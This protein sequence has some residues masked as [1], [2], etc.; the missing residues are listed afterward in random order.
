MFLGQS[1]RLPS[2]LYII[3]WRC[4]LWYCD[5]YLGRTG[6]AWMSGDGCT[7][8]S[9]C[10]TDPGCRRAQLH[11]TEWTFSLC[12]LYLYTLTIK[13]KRSM[14]LYWRTPTMAQIN[15]HRMFLW[16][17][18]PYSISDHWRSSFCLHLFLWG[19]SRWSQ[20]SS[21]RNTSCCYSSEPLHLN[22][23]TVTSLWWRM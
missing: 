17:K 13:W 22:M 19:R 9:Q 6:T 3:V 7:T 11:A 20:V 5:L 4:A 15:L 10:G 8:R 21:S 14:F 23:G 2:K 16:S 1:L 18:W 12:Q